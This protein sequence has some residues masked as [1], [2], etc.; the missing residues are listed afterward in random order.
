MKI[1]FVPKVKA[2]LKAIVILC[3]KKGQT[4]VEPAA[5]L[6]I[7]VTQPNSSLNML[8][9]SLLAFFFKKAT[10][11]EKQQGTLEG[12]PPVSDMAVLTE[13]GMKIG[14]F[15]WD[16]EQSGTTLKIHK[17]I[18]G[19]MDI[20]LRSGTVKKIKVDAKEGGAVD[21]RFR[22]YTTDV[23]ADTLGALAVLKSQELDIELIAPEVQVQQQTL[24]EV[25]EPLTPAEGLA[26]ALGLPKPPRKPAAKK[27]PA[28]AAKASGGSGNSRLGRAVGRHAA[29]TARGGKK[30]KA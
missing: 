23:D 21:W 15:H 5:E 16:G 26:N 30:A 2:V 11:K 10:Q 8:D 22:F 3:V 7:L 13:P 27:A 24:G 28:K 19:D 12:V 6:E 20:T 17:G 4:D 1:E 29:K 14:T 9:P 25:E 18:T